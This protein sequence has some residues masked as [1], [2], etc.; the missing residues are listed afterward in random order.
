PAALEGGLVK[1]L[2]LVLALLM[3]AAPSLAVDPSEM[4]KDPALEARAR[5]LS[6]ELRC[7]VCQ[8]QSIDD[9]AAEGAHDMR[10]A[11]RDRLSAGDSDRQVR[12]F[13]VARY[14][15]FVLLDPPF[16]PR[17][18]ILWLGAPLLLLIAGALLW[19]N[20]RRKPA[21]TPPLPLSAEERKKLD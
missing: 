3:L 14:G 1:R 12:A 2:T 8:N 21:A 13:M 4:L 5:T 20:A 17:T 9:S 16:K 15:D 19:L 18:L 11:V 7:V 10:R 6:R